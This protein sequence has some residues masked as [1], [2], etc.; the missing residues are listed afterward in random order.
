LTKFNKYNM[1]IKIEYSCDFSYER[2]SSVTE[3]H[4]DKKGQR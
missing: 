1:K 3:M 2:Y 4:R